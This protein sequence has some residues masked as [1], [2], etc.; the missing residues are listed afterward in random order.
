MIRSRSIFLLAFLSA[1]GAGLSVGLLWQRSSSAEKPPPAPQQQDGW[2]AELNLS[3]EQREKIKAIWTDAMKNN[4]WQQQREQREAAVAE[5]DEALKTMLDAGQ[6]T[7]YDEI[8][9]TFQ[10]KM[11]EF[12]A[13]NKKSRDAAYEKTKAILTETQ[14]VQYDELRKKRM[15]GRGRHGEAGKGPPS[16]AEKKSEGE[17]KKPD[18]DVKKKD[19]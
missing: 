12:S 18:V 17:T 16:S 13:E 11:D 2:L 4:N 14:R 15:E 10:K 3:P 9:A 6:K 8:L 1:F 19:D 5:R 7:K